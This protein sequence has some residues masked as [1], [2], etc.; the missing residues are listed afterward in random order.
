MRRGG[1]R[2]TEFDGVKLDVHRSSLPPGKFQA[3]NGGDPKKKGSWS[4]RRGMRHTDIAAAAGGVDT[5]LGFST[6]DG[7]FALI[8]VDGANANGFTGTAEQ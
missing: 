6:A 7:S 5:L 4:R 1:Q 3:D 8:V 2:I